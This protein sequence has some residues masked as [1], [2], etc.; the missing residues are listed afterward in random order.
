MNTQQ[1]ADNIGKAT[2]F[3]RLSTTRSSGDALPVIEEIPHDEAMAAVEKLKVYAPPQADIDSAHLHMSAARRMFDRDLVVKP[4]AAQGAD[5]EDAS[6]VAPMAA[7]SWRVS[8]DEFIIKIDAS[9]LHMS[10]AKRLFDPHS[11]MENEVAEKDESLSPEEGVKHDH[12]FKTF[13]NKLLRVYT[14]VSSRK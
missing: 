14:S 2:S 6:L 4:P 11:E 3:F 10:A 9:P 1:Q 7:S 12:E 13:W 5:D 8:P